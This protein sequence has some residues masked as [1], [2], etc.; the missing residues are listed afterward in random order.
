MIC[1]DPA[2][3]GL[4]TARDLAEPLIDG[5]NPLQ[6]TLRRLSRCGSLD[7]IAILS[8]DIEAAR[9][10]VGPVAP[11][12]RIEFHATQGP[13]LARRADAVRGAR[14]WSASC[15]RGGLGGLSV[16]D[17]V[18]APAAMLAVMEQRG[19][20]GAVLVG[21]DWA[22]VDP[23]LVDQVVGRFRLRPRGEGAHRLTFCQAPPGLG[24]CVVERTL[25]KELAEKGASAG[26]FAS[27]GGLLAYVPIA[28]LADPIAKPVCVMVAPTVRDAQARFI[29]DS[30]PRRAALA[31][32][33]VAAGSEAGAEAIVA[34]YRESPSAPQQLVLELCTGRRAGMS[35]GVEAPE[36]PVLGLGH[37]EALFKELSALR[38]DA[39]LTLAGAGDPLLHADVLRIVSLAR[40]AGIAGVHVRTDLLCDAAALPGLLECGADVI[41]VNLGAETAP[42]YRTVMGVDAFD[43]VRANLHRLLELRA[44]RPASGGLPTPWIVPRITRCDA[45]YAEIEPFYDRWIMQAGA[46][47]IDP[48]HEAPHGA[49]IE[50]LPV[51]AGAAR[52]MARERMLVLSDGKVPASASDLSG[53]RSVADAFRDGLAAAWRRVLTRHEPHLAEPKPEL[54]HGAGSRARVASLGAL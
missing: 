35:R 11:G 26:V 15:W 12:Q 38:A 45:T 20:D 14:L 16:Y 25:M 52:R 6:L 17:E 31:R 7:G 37:A 47:V 13:P 41:S 39:A 4:G 49:R 1:V 43:R 19:I 29:P 5:L 2:R 22:A 28:P 24:A 30:A 51:P 21:A 46:A 27:V 34:Q 53:E 9:R 18:C 10:L 8:Q 23:S 32:A 48:P 54:L 33:L 44:A 40:G 3:G 50:P 42:T 36:R